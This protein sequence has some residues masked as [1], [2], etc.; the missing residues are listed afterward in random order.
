MGDEGGGIVWSKLISLI[1][2]ILSFIVLFI[3]LALA[4][5]MPS[6]RS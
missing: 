3:L 6:L 4:L 2:I 1:F 5:Y